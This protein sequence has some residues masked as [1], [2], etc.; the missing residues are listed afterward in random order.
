MPGRQYD[1]AVKAEVLALVEL[2][3]SAQR[4]AE[5][6][7]VSPRQAQAWAQQARKVAA[8]EEHPAIINDWYRLTRRTQSVLHDA[9]DTLQED[10]TGKQ[11]LKHMTQLTV[12]A[13]VGTDKLQRDREPKYQVNV[14]NTGPIAIIINAQQPQIEPDSIEGEATLLDELPSVCDDP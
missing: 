14:A 2:G 4:A 13:G 1:R 12:L 10:N 11:A 8:E 9:L 7:N 5:R 3:V 6:L